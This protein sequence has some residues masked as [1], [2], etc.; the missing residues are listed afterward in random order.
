MPHIIALW[1]ELQARFGP[2][3]SPLEP[4][5]THDWATDVPASTLLNVLTALQ[6]RGALHHL[7][8]ITATS[9]EGGFWLLYHFWAESGL[10]LRVRVEEDKANI[11]SL[12]KFWPVAEW[13]E[14]EIHDLFGLAFS[15]YQAIEPLLFSP[16]ESREP[17][18]RIKG[19]VE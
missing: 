13:Y 16:E 4:H 15:G 10:T 9:R 17:P 3:L 19:G 7:S 5:G 12:R 8:A 6:E 2:T 1:Q 14:R 11:P 18:L